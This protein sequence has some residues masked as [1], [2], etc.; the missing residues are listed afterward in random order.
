VESE[1][2]LFLSNQNDLNEE[3]REKL[4]LISSK[5]AQLFGDFVIEVTGHTDDQGDADDNLRLSYK[6]ALSVV[7]YLSQKNLYHHRFLV[8]SKGEFSPT[9]SNTTEEGRAQNRRVEFRIVPDASG[10]ITLLTDPTDENASHTMVL[11]QAAEAPI[12]GEEAVEQNV[13]SDEA[14][15]FTQE[16]LDQVGQDEKQEELVTEPVIEEPKE[17]VQEKPKAQEKPSS[18]RSTRKESDFY[19]SV[20]DHAKWKDHTY[21]ERKK[22]DTGTPYVW[23]GPSWT[24][25][26]QLDD[27]GQADQVHA[28]KTSF[29]AGVGWTSFLEDANQVFVTLEGFANYDRF[30]ANAQ[31]GFAS[32]QNEWSYG[33]HVIIGKYFFK[34]W[35]LA[36]RVGFG[37]LPF[38]KQ[39]G[40]N[41]NY[42]IDY[43]GNAGAQTEVVAWRFSQKGDV[44]LQAKVFY[45]DVPLGDLDSGWQY[46]GALFADYDRY[47][48]TLD[49]TIS[50]FDALGVTTNASRFAL[51]VG[52]YF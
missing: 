32:S 29:S 19:I 14:I 48:L 40:A 38:L 49:Y 51:L 36:A 35:S 3:S 8:Q 20:P 26:S 18:T 39:S 43:I 33:G 4:N 31:A 16:N 17:V 11:A 30:D 13:A 46:G 27:I 45:F 44:G 28:S 47:R 25:L 12:A 50:D 2:V 6:R 41:L 10:K 7:T 52:A 21:D 37:G 15:D 1:Q 42:D 24:R 22:T 23:L 5:L 34:N 9:V